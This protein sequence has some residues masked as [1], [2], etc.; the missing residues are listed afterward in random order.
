[1]NLGM[2]ND[3]D[4]GFWTPIHL[5][6]FDIPGLKKEDISIEVTGR[7]LTISGERK[8][9]EHQ[10]KAS[11]HRME[12]SYGKFS[13]TFDLSDAIATDVIDASYENGVLKVAIPKAEASNQ[14]SEDTNYRRRQRFPQAPDRNA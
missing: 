13:R 3:F 4:H 12:R 5:L 1:M 7:Q 9:E 8:R 14:A 6:N 11:T 10:Q 2:L